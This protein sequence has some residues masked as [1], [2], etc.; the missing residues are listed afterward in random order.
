MFWVSRDSISP[1]SIENRNYDKFELNGS[2]ARQEFLDFLWR[3]KWFA[4][5]QPWKKN[6]GLTI[7]L[8]NN[9]VSICICRFENYLNFFIIL[10]LF[11]F[12]RMCV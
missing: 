8:L 5:Q 6:T 7:R 2:L 9:S 1:V 12:I 11:Q 3:P 4:K 10:V